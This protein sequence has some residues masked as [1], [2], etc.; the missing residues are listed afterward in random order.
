MS[1][2]MSENMCNNMSEIYGYAGHDICDE[3]I[4]NNPALMA[5]KNNCVANDDFAVICQE[6]ITPCHSTDWQTVVIG[7]LNNAVSTTKCDDLL[8][9]FHKDS[10][11]D[12][13]LAY[14]MQNHNAIYCRMGAKPLVIGI[15]N[16]GNYLA[17]QIKALQNVADKYIALAPGEKAKITKDKIIIYNKKG[18]KIKRLPQPID[19]ERHF[20][21][22]YSPADEIYCCTNGVN[23]AISALCND[24]KINLDHLKIS[25]RTADKIKHIVLI[26][27]GSS[28]NACLGAKYVFEFLCNIPTTALSATEFI[29]SAKIVDKNT[30]VIALS[31]TGETTQT[32]WSA[33][34][35]IKNGAKAVAVT[36][37]T[38]S[39]LARTV[40]FVINTDCQLTSSSVSLKSF[41]NSYLSLCL[42]A[43]YIGQKRGIVSQLYLSVAVKMAQLLAG[44]IV[45]STK[46]TR[47]LDMLTYML[48]DADNLIFTGC[49][50]DYCIA[51][52]ASA[53]MWD[54]AQINGKAL[55]MDMLPHT[56][57][58]NHT[59]VA[60]ISNK[61]YLPHSKKILQDAQKQGAKVIIVTTSSIETDLYPF[62]KIVSFSD[63]IPI[64]NIIPIVVGLYKATVTATD[65]SKSFC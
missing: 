10:V 43:L 50:I 11:A 35:A 1:K 21:Y 51:G 48:K 41:I 65:G 40:P 56:D 26:G 61:D 47:A 36:A 2:N 28:H 30:L 6:F 60:I 34:Y 13:T 38:T 45:E 4:L 16:Q 55:P 44:K 37:D 7:M 62:D 39:H 14:K 59:I 29:H 64:F 58:N 46:P 9:L 27:E 19:K 5:N 32:V 49:G 42:L 24:G 63:N 18:I 25:S 8:K 52:E 15:S 31:Q 53:K 22:D 17:N 33:D 23:T 54:I 57:T 20:D 3:Y 12:L